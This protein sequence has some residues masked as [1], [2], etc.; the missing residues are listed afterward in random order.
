MLTGPSVLWLLICSRRLWTSARNIRFCFS[1]LLTYE[2][3]S[4]NSTLCAMVS[5]KASLQSCDK[6][7]PSQNGIWLSAMNSVTG[8]RYAII[9]RSTYSGK[10]GT[11]FRVVATSPVMR[12]RSRIPFLVRILTG[13]NRPSLIRKQRLKPILSCSL[14]APNPRG[15]CLLW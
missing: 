13:Y 14:L 5:F 6:S 2:T 15:L 3:V 12:L 8:T 9:P 1:G 7:R 11:R 4:A 10:T